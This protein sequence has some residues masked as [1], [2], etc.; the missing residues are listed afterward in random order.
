ME[1]QELSS[2][3]F[4]DPIMIFLKFFIFC[5]CFKFKWEDVG[6]SWISLSS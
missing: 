5:F 2:L 3:N 6:N 1:K 4:G